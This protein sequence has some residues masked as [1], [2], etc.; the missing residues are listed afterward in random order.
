M[1][2]NH[3][4]TLLVHPNVDDNGL[5][6]AYRTRM[7]AV[8]P[9]V[10][11]GASEEATKQVQYAY[12]VLS[13]PTTRAAYDRELAEAQQAP[14]PRPQPQTPSSPLFQSMQQDAPL[15]EQEEEELEYAPIEVRPL[16][17]MVAQHWPLALGVTLLT[18]VPVVSAGM[19]LSSGSGGGLLPAL[20]LGLGLWQVIAN[21]PK[22]LIAMAALAALGVVAVV[23]EPDQRVQFSGALGFDHP[24][25][26]I[27]T[28]ASAVALA[29]LPAVGKIAAAR[30]F[31]SR[32]A[33]KWEQF[34]ERNQGLL[35]F[36]PAY[37]SD[38][39]SLN[40]EMQGVD[41]DAR[42]DIPTF[43]SRLKHPYGRRDSVLALR[44]GDAEVDRIDHRCFLAWTDEQKA[45]LM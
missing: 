6:A 45:L 12:D 30:I 14:T 13:D 42:E 11:P 3:Y 4:E 44:F 9:D 1:S 23:F 5:K 18:L 39:A 27:L 19:L 15:V 35:I 41:W 31:S 7:R 29:A 34:A 37:I 26:G 16:G 17:A 20:I 36:I 40:P 38:I 10:N 22:S 24:L 28:V 8:H 33:R 32:R 43:Q 25:P 2:S 21:S